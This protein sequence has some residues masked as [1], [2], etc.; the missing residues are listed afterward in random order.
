M[1][2]ALLLGSLT[3][4]L[5]ACALAWNDDAQRRYEVKGA[6]DAVIAACTRA[7]DSGDLSEIER[8]GTSYN[9]GN[10]FGNKGEYD[11]RR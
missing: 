5:G 11:R 6:L 10:A 4:A 9:R 7:L 3:H 1:R 2:R 8:A